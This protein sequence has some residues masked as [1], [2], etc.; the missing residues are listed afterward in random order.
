MH[1]GRREMHTGLGGE[2]GKEM[3]LK[4]YTQMG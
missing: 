1:R 4:N 2:L 3:T